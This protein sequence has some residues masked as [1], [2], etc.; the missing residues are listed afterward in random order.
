MLC[1]S[2]QTHRRKDGSAPPLGCGRQF[3]RWTTRELLSSFLFNPTLEFSEYSNLTKLLRRQFVPV[4]PY[5]HNEDKSSLCLTSS[6]H[7]K[8]NNT[9][10]NPQPKE[11]FFTVWLNILLLRVLTLMMKKKNG[12]TNL[13]VLGLR[14]W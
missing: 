4:Y 12:L 5:I 13:E 7:N 14:C 1:C 2:I 10:S 3:L 9:I 11:F 8:K 6:K